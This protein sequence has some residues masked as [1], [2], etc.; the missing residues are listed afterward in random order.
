MGG[1]PI[2]HISQ[3]QMCSV[4]FLHN[5]AA[6]VLLQVINLSELNMVTHFTHVLSCKFQSPLAH[7]ISNHISTL[8][9]DVSDFGNGG[10]KS[11]PVLW[12]F[13]VYFIFKV[14]DEAPSQDLL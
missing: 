10:V 11:N 6:C 7:E 5:I 2:I 3:L 12:L 1:L 9:Y 4:H 14:S 8:M 13:N